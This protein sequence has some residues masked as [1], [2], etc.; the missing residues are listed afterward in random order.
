MRNFLSFRALAIIGFAGL[1]AS[2]A[3]FNPLMNVVRATWPERE[4]IGVICDYSRS[5]DQIDQLAASASP[6]S[7]ITVVDTK[8]P[9]M[10]PS[11]AQMLANRKADFLVLIP[12]DR[13]FGEGRFDATNVVRRLALRGI[14][15]VG[16]GPVSIEQ[17][18]VFSV[19]DSTKGEL[20]VTNKLRGT[21]SV[22]LPDKVLFTRGLGRGLASAGGA[23][24]EVVG[25]P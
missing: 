22:I 15:S 2:A 12:E 7:R 6:S 17:G 16:T 8:N 23:K 11:A 10:G 4:H 24:V 1:A 19:G 3:D 5:K 25:L 18:A 20:L 21:I 13:Y 14:P 9:L